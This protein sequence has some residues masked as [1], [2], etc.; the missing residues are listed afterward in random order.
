MTQNIGIVPF[1]DAGAAFSTPWPNF[2]S[3]LRVAAGVGLRYYTGVGPIRLDVAT[4]LN[5]RPEDSRVAIFIGI[6]ESF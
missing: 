3:T 2:N 1:L 6:G 4:P 5:P